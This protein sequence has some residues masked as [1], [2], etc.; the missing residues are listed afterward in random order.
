MQSFILLLVVVLHTLEVAVEL[1]V[2]THHVGEESLVLLDQL[3]LSLV[4][5]VGFVC[6]VFR[7]KIIFGAHAHLGLALVLVKNLLLELR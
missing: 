2:L 1:D 3:I 4:R 5:L 7:I 6:V